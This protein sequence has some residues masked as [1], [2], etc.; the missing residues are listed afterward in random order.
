MAE[1]TIYLELPASEARLV[2]LNENLAAAE[3]TLRQDE[4]SVFLFY[5]ST[6]NGYMTAGC[7]GEIAFRSAHVSELW[8]HEKHRGQGLGSK[9][10][11]AAEDHAVRNGCDRIHL[12]TRNEKARQLYERLSYV[13]FGSLPNYEGD[14]TFYY[15]EKQLA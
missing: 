13:I 14:N 15:L 5:I 12:E 9:L 8:V 7:K 4:C 2:E 1:M 10:L 6:A 11:A 3:Q